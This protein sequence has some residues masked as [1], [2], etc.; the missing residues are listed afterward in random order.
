MALMIRG[1]RKGNEYLALQLNEGDW[2]G[3]KIDVGQQHVLTNLLLPDFF[4][5]TSVFSSSEFS[6]WQFVLTQMFPKFAQQKTFMIAW[7]LAGLVG[8]STSLGV[9][10]RELPPIRPPFQTTRTRR[11]GSQTCVDD[12][13]KSSFGADQTYWPFK[14]ILSFS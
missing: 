12:A 4:A 8:W 11:S 10:W 3:C 14:M 6:P 2:S 13:R 5:G 1:W 9:A 7:L